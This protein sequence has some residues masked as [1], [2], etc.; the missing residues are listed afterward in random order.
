LAL[1]V[2]TLQM[3]EMTQG[4]NRQASDR[5]SMSQNSQMKYLE[6]R[7]LNAEKTSGLSPHNPEHNPIGCAQLRGFSGGA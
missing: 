5:S 6:F 4:G 2:I 3:G 1:F 7:R